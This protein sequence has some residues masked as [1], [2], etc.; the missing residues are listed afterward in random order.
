MLNF[1]CVFVNYVSVEVL[2]L[3]P[4]RRRRNPIRL[5]SVREISDRYEFH[6]N[7]VRAWVHRDG[8]RHYRK[9]PGGKMLIREDDL[10]D[11]LTKVY[12]L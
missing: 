1:I 6:P 4:R 5:L 12:E 2:R 11:F 9:G 10:L 8:L 7:T 3:A